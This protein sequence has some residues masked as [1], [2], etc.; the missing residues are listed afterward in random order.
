MWSNLLDSYCMRTLRYH[1]YTYNFETKT[2]DI[3]LLLH[4]YIHLTAFIPGQ[5]G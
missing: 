5:P 2:M 3:V 4:Y 1:C